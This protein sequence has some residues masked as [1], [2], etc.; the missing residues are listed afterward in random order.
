MAGFA[1]FWWKTR[2][3]WRIVCAH[4]FGASTLYTVAVSLASMKTCAIIDGQ[5]ERIY[6]GSWNH[7]LLLSVFFGRPLAGA[8][9]FQKRNQLDAPMETSPAADAEVV[10]GDN[11]WGATRLLMVAVL[12]CLCFAL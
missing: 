10:L 12:Y 2:G 1:A 11:V 8:I 6:T 9:A 4:L 7:L 3:A 5:Q